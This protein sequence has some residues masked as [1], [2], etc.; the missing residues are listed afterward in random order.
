MTLVWMA[1]L[2]RMK[3]AGIESFAR[4]PPTFAAASTTYCGR[5]PS[6]KRRT[7]TASVSSGAAEAG[8]ALPN[9]ML[10]VFNQQL[11]P[12]ELAGARLELAHVR[13]LGTDFEGAG[14]KHTEDHG[15]SVMA[16]F[17]Q[18]NR[19]EVPTTTVGLQT[20][21]TTEQPRADLVYRVRLTV[22]DPQGELRQGQPVTVSVPAD[23]KR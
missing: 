15:E 9:V 13:T 17:T 12:P 19:I 23:G 5:S 16:S 6:K 8:A 2:S 21:S 1:R 7:A 20:D 14:R 22:D 10:S 3:S 11:V 18:S 4:M